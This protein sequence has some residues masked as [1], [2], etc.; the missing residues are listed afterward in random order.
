MSK[1]QIPR[2][3]L[4][5]ANK[6]KSELSRTYGDVFTPHVISAIVSL[7]DRQPRLSNIAA[8]VVLRTL[9]ELPDSETED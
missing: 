8:D 4:I 5:D 3:V 2:L 1:K 7:I 6:L 9:L